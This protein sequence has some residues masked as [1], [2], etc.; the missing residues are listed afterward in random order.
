MTK[1][2]IGII[3]IVIAAAVSVSGCGS[4]E[5]VSFSR[6]KVSGQTMES[7]LFQIKAEMPDNWEFYTDSQVAE[8]NS[9]SSSDAA[10]FDKAIKEKD[11]FIDMA[12]RSK[13][14]SN[15]IIAIPNPDVVN[16]NIF[17]SE[18]AYAE[19]TLRGL[20]S[21]IP[22]AEISTLT[23]AGKEHNAIKIDNSVSGVAVKQC[24]V[25]VKRGKYVGM[26]TFTC[27]TEEELNEAINCFKS[28]V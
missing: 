8:L 24:M 12:C 5:N 11:V 7:E 27:F 10:A 18:K 15:Y 3:G 26:I 13:T 14:G 21:S 19:E 20:K 16:S 1:R 22:S 25:F 4:I 28:N 6:A 17:T 9:M 23:F 2:R